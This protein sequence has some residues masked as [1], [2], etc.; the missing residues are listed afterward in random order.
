VRLLGEGRHA[1]GSMVQDKTEAG[2]RSLAADPRVD[3]AFYSMEQGPFDLEALSRF[4]KGARTVAT[5]SVLVRIPP[6]GSDRQAARD[7]VSSLFALGVDG[8]VFP[9]TQSSEE[10]AFAVS[11]LKS[12]SR[13]VASR[14]AAERR[15][16]VLHDRGSGCSCECAGYRADT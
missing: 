6:I 12:A 2:G 10:V 5:K 4:L 14:S 11:L 9:H 7:R 8:I 16:R 1:F 13:G 3:F 15:D